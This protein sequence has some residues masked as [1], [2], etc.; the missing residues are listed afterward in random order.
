MIDKDSFKN[1]RVYHQRNFDFNLKN[2][3]ERCEI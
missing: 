2:E 3:H 1:F